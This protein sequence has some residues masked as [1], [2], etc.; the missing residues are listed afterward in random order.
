MMGLR[1]F[2]SYLDSLT[3][4]QDISNLSGIDREIA[5]ILHRD[6]RRESRDAEITRLKSLV[7]AT[8]IDGAPDYVVDAY[9]KAKQNG[10][11]GALERFERA[12]IRARDESDFLLLSM[13]MVD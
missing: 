6:I 2:D 4:K 13:A 11:F 5:C 7:N 9:D 8:D 10:T 1:D 12:L 3:S